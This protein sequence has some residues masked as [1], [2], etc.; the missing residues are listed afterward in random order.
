MTGPDETILLEDAADFDG[1]L[2]EA[3][4]LARFRC[5]QE[6]VTTTLSECAPRVDA[7]G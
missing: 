2:A 4:P 7:C 6:P 5:M 1:C 3:D